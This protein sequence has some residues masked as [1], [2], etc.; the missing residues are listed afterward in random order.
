MKKFICGWLTSIQTGAVRYLRRSAELNPSDARPWLEQGF[1]AEAEDNRDQAELDLHQAAKLD[2]R[3]SPAWALANFYFRQNNMPGF[4]LWAGRY[5]KYADGNATGLFR[6]DWSRNPQA[7]AL[8]RDF[9]P[10]TCKELEA[11]ASFV[12]VHAGPA[13]LAQVEQQLAIVRQQ[14]GSECGYGWGVASAYG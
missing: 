2:V 14:P 6:L 13:D 4:F 10:L 5:R 1:I 8:L 3:S 9:H 7:T 11:M 12:E